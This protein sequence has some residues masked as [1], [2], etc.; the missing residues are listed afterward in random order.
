M[1]ENQVYIIRSSRNIISKDTSF[2]IIVVA[3]V[4][5][6][7]FNLLQFVESESQVPLISY[8]IQQIFRFKTKFR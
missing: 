7:Q 8:T 2:K 1:F 4:F 6:F 5:L 3:A